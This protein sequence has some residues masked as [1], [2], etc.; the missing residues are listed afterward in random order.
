MAEKETVFVQQKKAAVEKGGK[1]LKRHNY[2]GITM[3]DTEK[4]EEYVFGSAQHAD[5]GTRVP[6]VSRRGGIEG[7]Q[8]P[9]GQVVQG[10]VITCE[11][12]TGFRVVRKLR[13]AFLDKIEAELS[14]E[15]DLFED[16]AAPDAPLPP[17]LAAPELGEGD[18]P[19][20]V[21]DG[22]VEP[23]NILGRMMDAVTPP[24]APTMEEAQV[25]GLQ[26]A[27][28]LQPV[29]EKVRVKMQGA[30]GQYK[31]VYTH[32]VVDEQFVVLVHD[33]DDSA[34]VPPPAREAFSVSCKGEEYSVYYAGINFELP[35]INAGVQVMVRSN[36]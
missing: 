5:G 7:S 15:L 23:A 10:H 31:G 32:L 33:L 24:P 12:D 28:F 29:T 14:G 25:A 36:E 27:T 20:T 1:A 8:N 18:M 35:F 11:E 4:P 13:P 9:Y 6:L 19:S 26:A 3:L 16:E 22:P 2:R 17:E 21:H 30:F 34:F